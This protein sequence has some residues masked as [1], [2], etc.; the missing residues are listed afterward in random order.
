MYSILCVEVNSS[1]LIWTKQPQ[2]I[3]SAY[4]RRGVS[5]ET[6]PHHLNSEKKK[7]MFLEFRPEYTR[8]THDVLFPHIQ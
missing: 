1:V 3:L 2:N 5:I 4:L 7:K 6:A 8:N